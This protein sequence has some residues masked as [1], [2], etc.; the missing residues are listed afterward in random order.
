MGTQYIKQ[1][2]GKW[3][4]Y[5]T[6]TDCLDSIEH[7]KEKLIELEVER[8]KERFTVEIQQAL[9]R[10]EN[11]IQGVFSVGWKEAYRNTVKRLQKSGAH[12]DFLRILEE[13][14]DGSEEQ[15]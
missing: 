13:I 15:A 3:A 14:G 4:I 12:N 10:K 7:D 9:D 11:G 5:S 2:N 1:P 8:M 6:V